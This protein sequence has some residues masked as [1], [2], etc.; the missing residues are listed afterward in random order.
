MKAALRKQRGLSRVFISGFKSQA[1]R[2][3]GMGLAVAS[4]RDAEFRG[5]GQDA[6]TGHR[7]HEH[8]EQN[9]K[10]RTFH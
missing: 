7:P 9:K 1:A 8:Y 4:A 6:F 2:R 3:I 10:Q 5:F